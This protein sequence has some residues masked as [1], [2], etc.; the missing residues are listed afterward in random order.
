LK[1]RVTDKVS[2]SR[3]RR[4]KGFSLKKHRKTFGVLTTP[5]K[6]IFHSNYHLGL[7]SGILPRIKAVK[8]CFKIV[9]MPAKPYESL[10]QIFKEHGL[11]GL[12]I[13]TW[14]WIHPTIAHLIE[15]SRHTRVLV[16]NDPVPSLRVNSL[17]TDTDAGM[18][19]AIAHLVKKGRRKIGMLHGPWEVPFKVGQR[20]VKV[21]FVDTQLKVRGFIRALKTQRIPCDPTWLRSGAA[22]SEAE[23]YRVMKRWLQEKNLPEAIVCGNDDLAFGALKALK[24]AGKRAPQDMAVIGF[25]DNECA[26]SFSPPLTTVRQPLGQMGKDAVDILIRQIERPSSGTVSKRYLPKLIV[27]K[28]G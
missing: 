13:L 2:R 15:T 1:I 9:M 22:N 5:A 28:T 19:Q 10:D 21:T 11:D 20:K 25:D 17:S 7:L 6:D 23:G 27:R 26:K 12:M 14:R 18:A 24:K 4:T 3:A 8:G 16:V